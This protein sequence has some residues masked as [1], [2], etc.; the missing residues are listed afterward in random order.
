LIAF[1]VW[2]PAVAHESKATITRRKSAEAGIVLLQFL[3]SV[4]GFGRGDGG[5]LLSAGRLAAE[6]GRSGDERRAEDGA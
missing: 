5:G 3:N 1:A 4:D 2:Q 6:V